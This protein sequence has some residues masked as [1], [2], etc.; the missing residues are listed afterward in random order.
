V[1]VAAVALAF[2]AWLGWAA[3]DHS[4][5]DVT[6][7]LH[8]YDVV[9]PHQV[10]VVIDITRTDGQHVVCDVLAQA[11]DHSAVGETQVAVRAGGADTVQVSAVIR[12]DR[13]A[14]TATVS[15]CRAAD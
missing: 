4:H 7:Q 2:L 14:T 8:G 1:S 13:E 12:T 9:S 5:P 3:W 6:G 10:R 15:N 11:E